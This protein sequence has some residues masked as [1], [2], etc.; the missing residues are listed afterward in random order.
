MLVGDPFSLRRRWARAKVDTEWL[1]VWDVGYAV[2]TGVVTTLAA[3]GYSG[4]RIE[5]IAVPLVLGLIA[6]TGMF[7][8]KNG[9]EFAWHFAVAGYKNEI[10]DLK[11]PALSVKPAVRFDAP[12]RIEDPTMNGRSVLYRIPIHYESI[13]DQIGAEAH[14][15]PRIQGHELVRP[16]MHLE[17]RVVPTRWMGGNPIT[18]RH[19]Q[20]AYI[21]LVGFDNKGENNQNCYAI[22]EIQFRD[23][24]TFRE[25]IT[26]PANDYL[27]RLRI[28]Y[29]DKPHDEKNYRVKVD[30]GEEPLSLNEEADS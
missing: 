28:L 5:D 1:S 17:Q 13:E 20:T 15:S 21:D 19:G 8:L 27:I 10:D 16:A 11:N 24:G 12:F 2:T 23:D 7:L 18:L 22:D 9:L 4:G 14:F 25:F 26:L 6:G 3:W 29:S 30:G